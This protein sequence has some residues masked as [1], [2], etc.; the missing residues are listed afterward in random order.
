MVGGTFRNY[1][2]VIIS[3][4]KAVLAG[5]TIVVAVTGCG[6]NSEG[7]GQPVEGTPVADASV[8]PSETPSPSPSP[9]ESTTMDAE[10][11]A[12]ALQAQVPSVVKVTVI[13]EDNDPN[14]LIGRPNGYVSAAVVSDQGGDQSDSEPGVA[15]GAT[16][17]VFEDAEAAQR[18]SDYIQGILEDAPL[19]G[20]EYHYLSGPALLRVSGEI[21]P[22]MAAEYEEA[23]KSV[24]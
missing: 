8:T 23:F 19:F 1:R 4:V 14:D 15:Y 3:K 18:R 16:V 24:E 9:T 13:T 17:E 5:L 22:S 12:K 6:G 21:K 10:A 20:T 2:G 7:T 11:I